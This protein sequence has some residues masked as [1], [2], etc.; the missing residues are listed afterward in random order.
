MSDSPQSAGG[1]ARAKKLTKE[2]RSEIAR[3]AAAARWAGSEP[4]EQ[5]SPAKMHLHCGAGLVRNAIN[6]LPIPE[7]ENLIATLWPE[8]PRKLVNLIAKFPD[9]TRVNGSQL[10]LPPSWSALAEQD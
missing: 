2:Q 9:E 4:A 8:L 1:Q 7:R 3:A 6:R 5:G 10:Q